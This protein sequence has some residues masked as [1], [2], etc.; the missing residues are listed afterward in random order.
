MDRKKWLEIIKGPA[1]N[2]EVKP[3]PPDERDKLYRLPL[4]TQTIE[5]PQTASLD[6]LIEDSDIM[7]QYSCPFCEAFA[8]AGIV[9]AYLKAV[10]KLPPGGVSKKYL[11][12]MSKK[13]DGI[14]NQPGTFPR[15]TLKIAQKY[16][17]CPES[18]L[19]WDGDCSEPVITEE[20][21]QEAAK[22]RIKGYYRLNGWEEMLQALASGIFVNVGTIVTQDNWLD[23]DEYLLEPEGFYRGGH[24]HYLSQYDLTKIYKQFKE[25]LG[26]INSWGLGWGNKGR[27]WMAR[28]YAEYV[29]EDI[30]LPALMEAWAV[31]FENQPEARPIEKI[32][33]RIQVKEFLVAPQVI[34]GRTMLAVRE[35]FKEAGFA[36]HWDG[37]KGV[38]L[39]KPGLH[40]EITIGNRLYFKN[41]ILKEFLVAPRVID[42]RTMLPIREL[43]EDADFVVDWDGANGVDLWGSGKKIE[44]TIGQKEYRVLK[45]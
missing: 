31:T 7:N 36:V 38:T 34:D 40:F 12:W 28:H 33:D 42:G 5:V 45:I 43:F 14:P 10:G 23:G 18:M 32:E 24:G 27:Y 16:G 9:N 19:P 21:H 1:K 44:I 20:M 3:S 35:I 15:V 25:F 8:V 11:Y 39:T 30:G 2:W 41:G 22:Y 37:N 17:A 6:Y 29:L 4:Q 13:Y 26:G